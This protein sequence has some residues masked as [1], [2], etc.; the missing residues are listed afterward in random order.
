MEFPFPPH[1]L[2]KYQVVKCCAESKEKTDELATGSKAVAG[3]QLR[4]NG[5][6]GTFCFFYFFMATSEA[7]GSSQAR[8][9]I[10]A[11]EEACATATATPNPSHSLPQCRIL[12]PLSE[13]RDQTHI[14]TETCWVLNLLGHNGNSTLCSG[15]PH[16]NMALPKHL[17]LPLSP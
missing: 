10:G 1:L 6:T 14:L 4:A 2:L 5:E 9:R 13:A 17:T 7:H 3:T 11:T 8:G 12:N 15:H 16:W